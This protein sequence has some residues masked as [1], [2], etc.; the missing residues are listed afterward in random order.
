MKFPLLSSM[1]VVLF[2]V[3]FASV[4]QIMDLVDR[5][6]MTRFPSWEIVSSSEVV[7]LIGVSLFATHAEVSLGTV[8]NHMP[9]YQ[10][11]VSWE[12]L[13]LLVLKKPSAYLPFLETR[14][15]LTPSAW[16][17]KMVSVAAEL[18]GARRKKSKVKTM[19]RKGMVF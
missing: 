2:L 4:D 9:R 8:L 1:A 10:L 13:L 7:F 19:G 15:S 12:G 3:M 11:V 16:P 6:K 5:F 17:A 18:A 14:L